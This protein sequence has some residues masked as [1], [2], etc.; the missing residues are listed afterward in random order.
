MGASAGNR[1]V[2]LV[3]D[4]LRDDYLGDNECCEVLCV[5]VRGVVDRGLNDF[6]EESRALGRHVTESLKRLLR[7]HVPDDRGFY[8]DLF[9]RNADIA[10][11]GFHAM[12]R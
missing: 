7:V 10:C 5:V 3:D 1:I 9:R 2:T 6:V 4:S 8:L 12:L 11:D